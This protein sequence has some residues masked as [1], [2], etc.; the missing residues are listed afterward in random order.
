MNCLIISTHFAIMVL[1]LS[2]KIVYRGIKTFDKICNSRMHAYSCILSCVIKKKTN[3]NIKADEMW[4]D[5]E[6]IPQ[7]QITVGVK[8]F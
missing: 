6:K 7:R 5:D 8:V 4:L 2:F 3:K 1:M